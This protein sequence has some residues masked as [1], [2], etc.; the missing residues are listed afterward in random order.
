MR[1]SGSNAGRIL[2]AVLS[3]L[4]FLPVWAVKPSARPLPD[5]D[6]AGG[7]KVG[8]PAGV[9][10]SPPHQAAL[11]GLEKAASAKIR[12]TYNAVSHAPRSIGSDRPLSSPSSLDHETI[13]R[14]FLRSHRDLWGFSDQ[15]V[16][17]LKL[18]AAYTDRHN[19]ASHVFFTQMQAGVPV[20]PGTLS[21]NLN[22]KGQV[23]SVQGDAFPGAR[24]AQAARLS[25]EEAAEIA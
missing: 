12:V 22:G 18:D 1:Y 17:D 13:A 3:L 16:D 25:P 24:A 21:V 6:A 4:I 23:M 15:E 9:S 7:L 8:L 10:A 5:F 19:G 14:G 20:F 11:R 2:L